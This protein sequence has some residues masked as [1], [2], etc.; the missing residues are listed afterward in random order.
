MTIWQHVPFENEAENEI[1][2]LRK[3]IDHDDKRFKYPLV[4]NS[5]LFG[6]FQS[7]RMDVKSD[8]S[9]FGDIDGGGHTISFDLFI[10]NKITATNANRHPI[11]VESAND[12]PY[13]IQ[14]ETIAPTG[15]ININTPVRCAPTFPAETK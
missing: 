15:T 8:F 6:G 2:F 4:R 14:L 3:R 10:L 13:T 7:I 12:S 11:S 9:F 5:H 1:E